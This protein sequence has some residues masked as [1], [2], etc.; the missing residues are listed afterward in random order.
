M[1]PDKE[2]ESMEDTAKELFALRVGSIEELR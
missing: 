2:S 1:R